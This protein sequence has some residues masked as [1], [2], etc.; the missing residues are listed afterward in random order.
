MLH[1]SA[2]AFRVLAYLGIDLYQYKQRFHHGRP[3]KAP[4]NA[5]KEAYDTFNEQIPQPLKLLII[6]PKLTWKMSISKAKQYEVE[7]IL[8]G[9][10]WVL[11]IDIKDTYLEDQTGWEWT[12]PWSDKALEIENIEDTLWK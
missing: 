12:P 11:W 1:F 7:Q 10:L 6:P 2:L 4:I 8:H 9:S 5:S 3:S